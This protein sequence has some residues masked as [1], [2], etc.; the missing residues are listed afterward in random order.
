[1][2]TLATGLTGRNENGAYRYDAYI[3]FCS[4]FYLAFSFSLSYKV[5]PALQGPKL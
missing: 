5:I 1:M 3:R 2:I 4:F